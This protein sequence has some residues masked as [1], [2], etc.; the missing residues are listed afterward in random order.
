M[1]GIEDIPELSTNYPYEIVEKIQTYYLA[2]CFEITLQ[3][4]NLGI[5]GKATYKYLF[6]LCYGTLKRENE[7]RVAG[8]SISHIEAKQLNQ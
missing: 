7:N 3:I 2:K 5:R 6:C 4:F 8:Y 1:P